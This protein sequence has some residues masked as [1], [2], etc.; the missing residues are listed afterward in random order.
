MLARLVVGIPS[1]YPERRY[2][3][4]ADESCW[5]PPEHQSH[6]ACCGGGVDIMARIMATPVSQ[7]LGQSVVIEDIGGAGG[8]IGANMV[9][10]AD[11]D[12]YTLLFAGP[13]QPHCLR[14]IG[15]SPMT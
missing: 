3:T 10:K 5:S 7:A 15:I 4:P 2:R 9:A 8:A 11:P 6:Y 14:C 13:G 12:G 1:P